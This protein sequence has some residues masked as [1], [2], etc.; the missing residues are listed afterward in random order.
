MTLARHLDPTRNKLVGD[1]D[2]L[3]SFV[4]LAKSL[5]Q[6]RD[7]QELLTKIQ[8]DLFAVQV[9]IADPEAYDAELT[10]RTI[11]IQ[12]VTDRIEQNL[13]VLHHFILPEGNTAACLMHCVRTTARQIERRI[14]GYL[15]AST[16]LAAYLDKLSCLMFALARKVNQVG[17]REERAP[18][19][20][21][22]RE[23]RTHGRSIG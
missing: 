21:L 23:R 19:Y 11:E 13:P 22:E 6:D 10:F 7:L 17:A 15:K 4:G 18:E 9:S 16:G 14:T 2:H 3:N 12:K 5:I 1:L 20:F 8:N